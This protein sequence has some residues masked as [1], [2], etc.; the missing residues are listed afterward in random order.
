VKLATDLH[1]GLRLI[2]V[3]CLHS[4]IK[5]RYNVTVSSMIGG[6]T[7]TGIQLIIVK[8]LCYLLECKDDTANYK[9][10]SQVPRFINEGDITSLRNKNKIS[11]RVFDFGMCNYKVQL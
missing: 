8:F 1:V 9:L 5:Y 10:V 2:R 6:S 11:I 7:R 4:E 3:K